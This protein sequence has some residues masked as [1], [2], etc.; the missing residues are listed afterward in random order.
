ML[1]EPSCSPVSTEIA[2]FLALTRRCCRRP[3]REQGQRPAGVFAALLVLLPARYEGGSVAVQHPSTAAQSSFDFAATNEFSSHFLS[4]FAGCRVAAQPLA[5][6]RRLLLA[7][8]LV[9]SGPGPEPAARDHSAAVRRVRR[10]LSK[11]VAAAEAAAG[12]GSDS[13]E[14]AGEPVEQLQRKQQQQEEEEEQPWAGPEKLVYLLETRWA[15]FAAALV[16][17]ASLA[18]SGPPGVS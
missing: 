1:A 16:P 4:H 18:A 12:S 5:A 14:G 10:V 8:E 2:G 3:L 6:G 17:T 15:C 13:E 9:H 7:Y 11:W